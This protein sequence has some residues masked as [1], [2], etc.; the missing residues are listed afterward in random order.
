[1]A[2]IENRAYGNH[3]EIVLDDDYSEQRKIRDRGESDA[4]YVVARD[5]VE[6]EAAYLVVRNR[7]DSDSGAR[8][9]G[10]AR[11]GARIDRGYKKK[12]AR[13]QDVRISRLATLLHPDSGWLDVV[14]TSHL[15]HLYY[16]LEKDLTIYPSRLFEIPVSLQGLHRLDRTSWKAQLIAVIQHEGE[17]FQEKVGRSRKIEYVLCHRDVAFFLIYAAFIY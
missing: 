13:V 5:R 7:A 15:S 10:I 8:H 2:Q 12:N 4:A 9:Y 3:V 16:E 14:N 6:S 1:M 11:R 17:E